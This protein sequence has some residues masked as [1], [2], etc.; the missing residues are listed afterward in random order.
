[1]PEALKNEFVTES[2]RMMVTMDDLN[3]TTADGGL[4]FS[5]ELTIV[6]VSK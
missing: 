2:A 4:N 6:V 3:F 5:Y 1:M